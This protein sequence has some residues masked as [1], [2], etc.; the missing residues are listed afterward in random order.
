LGRLIYLISQGFENI[1]KNK[2]MF[3]ASV[4]IITTT[5]IT[6][7]IFM[8]LGE[9]AKALVEQMKSERLMV[10]WLNIDIAG[11]ELKTIEEEIKKIDGI[12]DITYRTK[13]ERLAG[14]RENTFNGD[15]SLMNGWEDSLEFGRNSYIISL[16]DLDQSEA[17]SK[18]IKLIDGINDVTYSSEVVETIAEISHVVKLVVMVVFIL[19]LGVSFLVI[20]NTIKLVLHSRRK[21]ISIMKYIGA[22]DGFVKT[23]FVVEAII[24]GFLGALISWFATIQL[25]N[26]FRG[27][28]GNMGNQFLTETVVLNEEIFLMNMFVG[29]VISC[30]A[31]LASI[32]K[33]L[34]V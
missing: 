29:I 8:I 32:K 20:S 9:N 21:E 14:I 11:E 17:I 27:T 4:L 28:M 6:L 13:E 1:W 7:G 23:P 18:K 15:G 25:Y 34:K 10:A 19:L 26:A 31:C 3:I 2:V 30:F 33:Y 16:D 12:V 24:V 22:T 5:M